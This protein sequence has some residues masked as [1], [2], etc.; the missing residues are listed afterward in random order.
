MIQ[1]FQ[2]N[3]KGRQHPASFQVLLKLFQ[4]HFATGRDQQS[5]DDFFTF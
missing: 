3:P 4:D 5:F 1:N 2:L